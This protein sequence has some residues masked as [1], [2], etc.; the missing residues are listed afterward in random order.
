MAP[1]NMEETQNFISG[2]SSDRTHNE[3]MPFSVFPVFVFGLSYLFGGSPENISH[4]TSIT[5]ALVQYSDYTH[6]Q[7]VAHPLGPIIFT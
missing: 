6:E 5:Q 4:T 1:G 2:F 3:K 7:S